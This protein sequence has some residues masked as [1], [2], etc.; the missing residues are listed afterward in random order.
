MNLIKRSRE[1]WDPFDFVRDLQDEMS[2]FLTISPLRRNGDLVRARFFEPDIEVREDSDHFVV[3]TD[4]PGIKKEELDIS[5]AG[6]L[7]TLKGERKAE[8][9]TKGKNYFYSERFHGAF[10]RTIELPTELDADKV[11]ATYKD[12][13]LELIIPKAENAKPKQIRVEVK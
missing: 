8:T 12:G 3:R 11:K 5:V 6:N 10:S 2:R 1:M 13:V 9:E 4:I 7:L